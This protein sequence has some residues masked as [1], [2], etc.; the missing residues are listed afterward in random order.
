MSSNSPRSPKFPALLKGLK[1][2]KAEVVVIPTI[3]LSHKANIAATTSA[4]VF[5]VLTG[6][7]KEGW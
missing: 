2:F 6:K 7:R 1:D 3:S 5:I 4:P